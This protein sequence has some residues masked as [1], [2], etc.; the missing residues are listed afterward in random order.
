MEKCGILTEK[1]KKT[2]FPVACTK[3]VRISRDGSFPD[4]V[5]YKNVRRAECTLEEFLMPAVEYIAAV[6]KCK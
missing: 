2:T 6:V 4:V 3:V 1:G 5:Y